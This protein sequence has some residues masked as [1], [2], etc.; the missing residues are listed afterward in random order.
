MRTLHSP[1]E[2]PQPLIGTAISTVKTTPQ[3]LRRSPTPIPTVKR[4]MRRTDHSHRTVTAQSQSPSPHSH[5]TV[6]GDHPHLSTDLYSRELLL[7]AG[8]VVLCADDRT[9]AA[10]HYDPR[11]AN[12]HEHDLRRAYQH[13]G[14]WDES[15]NESARKPE[16]ESYTDRETRTRRE[17]HAEKRNRERARGKMRKRKRKREIT[18]NPDV[19]VAPDWSRNTSKLRSRS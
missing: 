8:L 5:R 10:A 3:L 17:R 9:A 4:T 14:A 16:R 11:V 15:T 12:V 13:R 18:P 7:V 1:P 6:T 2:T 19:Q